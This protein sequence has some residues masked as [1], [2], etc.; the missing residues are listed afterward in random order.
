MAARKWM[1]ET[2][3]GTI[4]VVLLAGGAGAQAPQQPPAAG[5]VPAAAPVVATPPAAVVNGEPITQAELEGVLQLMPKP[6]SPPT[7]A[8]HKQM[9]ADALDM[10]VDDLLIR[11]YL[12]RNA[13]RIT[14]EEFTKEYETLL[15]ALKT[16]A[17]TLQDFLKDI[18]QTE[19]HLRLDI[20]KKLQWDKF[21]RQNVS[22]AALKKYYDDNRDFYDQVTVQVSHI[23]FRLPPNAPP[24]ERAQARARLGELRRQILANQISFA[25]A[26]R[27]FSQCRSAAQGGDI[28][29]I[30]RK[31]VVDERIAQAAFALKVGEVSDLVETEDGVQ[32]LTVTA[33]NPGQPSN[34][35]KIKDLVRENMAKE[36]WDN[37]VVQQRKAAKIEIK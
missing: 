1:M 11:Q 7:E 23:L 34:F 14:Q 16:R 10:L 21:I 13:P 18:H 26:A 35:D 17:M 3:G 25:D 5:R 30:M 37:L 31:W 19:D 22:D 4:A 9:R 33:R 36:I 28:G 27:K 29:F 20:V 2:L 12:N 32:L 24:A 8:Q 15:S 6:P